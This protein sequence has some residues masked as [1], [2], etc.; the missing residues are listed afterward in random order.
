MAYGCCSGVAVKRG[1]T[2]VSDN[3]PQFASEI[4][5]KF[6]QS[7]AFDH[8][9]SSPYSYYPMGNRE[10]ERAVKTVKSL[11]SKEEYPYLAL[12]SYRATPLQVGCS[13]AELLMSRTLWANIPTTREFRRPRTSDTTVFAEKDAALKVRQKQNFDSR[14]NARWQKGLNAG[15]SVWMRDKQLEGKVVREVAPRLFEVETSEG[16]F[17]QEKPI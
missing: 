14:H 1:S 12:L 13:T 6:A 9:S 17:M 7:Y 15:S 8:V 16:V 3:Q 5:Q 10:A 4:F 2:V 11:L